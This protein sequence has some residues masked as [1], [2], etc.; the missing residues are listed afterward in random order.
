MIQLGGG[1]DWNQGVG[2][3]MLQLGGCQGGENVQG[4]SWCYVDEGAN[5][6]I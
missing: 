3:A 6:E 4:A 1:G 2:I 5:I